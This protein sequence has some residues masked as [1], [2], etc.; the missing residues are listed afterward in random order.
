V[1][2]S[3]PA[4]ARAVTRLSGAAMVA[5]GLVLLAEQLLS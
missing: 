1:L 2:G 5:L 4:A 3:R